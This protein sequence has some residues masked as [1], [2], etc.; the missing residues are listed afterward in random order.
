[1]AVNAV[2]NMAEVAEART[3]AE[4]SEGAAAAA[5]SVGSEFGSVSVRVR[6]DCSDARLRPDELR[7]EGGALALRACATGPGQDTTQ[8]VAKASGIENS[9]GLS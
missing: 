1:M 6:A 2:I 4:T 5:P 7:L 8:I 3:G 9:A